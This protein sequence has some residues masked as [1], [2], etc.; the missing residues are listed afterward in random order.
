MLLTPD[1][2]ILTY[3]VKEFI[4]MGG[5]NC[6]LRGTSYRDLDGRSTDKSIKSR[7]TIKCMIKDLIFSA[8]DLFGV[9]HELNRTKST[10]RRVQK[11]SSF[12]RRE[13][14]YYCPIF[15]PFVERVAANKFGRET[16]V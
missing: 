10:D 9:E 12:R 8:A 2:A 13:I 4:L 14:D 15:F 16:L 1:N 7:P 6:T 3:P 11:M 5:C